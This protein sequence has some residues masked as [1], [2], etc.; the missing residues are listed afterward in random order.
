MAEN[1]DRIFYHFD[2]KPQIIVPMFYIC[3]SLSTEAIQEMN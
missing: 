2:G 1:G 3:N